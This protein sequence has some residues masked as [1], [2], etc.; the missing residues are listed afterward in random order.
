MLSRTIVAATAIVAV[1][2]EGV[3][4]KTT[5]GDKDKEEKVVEP[6]VPDAKPDSTKQA[7]TDLLNKAEEQKT[8]RKSFEQRMNDLMSK[9]EDKKTEQKSTAQ[10][11][12]DLMNKVEAQKTE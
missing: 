1:M 11:M 8:E 9:V 6:V 4:L 10:A 2:A 5:S 12:T 7:M 3:D